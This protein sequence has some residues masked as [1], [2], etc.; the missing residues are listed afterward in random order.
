MKILEQFIMG[1]REDQSL[2]EDGLFINEDFIAVF[3]GVTSKSSRTFGGKTGGRAA[4]EKAVEAMQDMPFDIDA[5]GLFERINSG[6]LSL[7]DGNSTGEA[8]VC[9]VVFS[10]HKNEIWSL[11][12]CQY[13]IIYKGSNEELYRPN[14]KHI[15]RLLSQ[16]RALVLEISKIEGATDEELLKNDTGREFILPILKKQNLLANYDGNFGYAVLNGTPFVREKIQIEKV[17]IGDTV[18]LASDGYPYL[19]STLEE[20]EKEL[21]R[22]IKENPL[23]DDIFV[24]TKGILPGN[25]SFDDRTFIKFIV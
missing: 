24:S 17:N 12:D 19:D 2:C 15:D 23:C 3:D 6:V 14:D 7:Y 1:K 20:S 25:K 22:T 16:V 8:A 5:N 13:R 9:A 10:R 21:E 18:I 11:G 4:M